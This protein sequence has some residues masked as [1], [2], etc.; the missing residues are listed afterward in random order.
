MTPHNSNDTLA[1][2]RTL[3]ADGTLLQH[4][5]MAGSISLVC[6]NRKQRTHVGETKIHLH[7]SAFPPFERL[8]EIVE[9][10]HATGRPVAIHCVT[11]AE[12]VF[13]LA[14]LSEASVQAGDRIEHAS[15]TPPELMEQLRE[16][17]LTVVTQPNFIAERGDAYLADVPPR[18]QDW[19]YRCRGFLTTGIGLAGGTD[20]PFGDADPWN[21]MRAAVTRTTK[22]GELLGPSECLTPEQALALFL[23]SSAAPTTPRRITVGERADLCLLTAPWSQAREPPLQRS[24]RGNATRRRANL[25]RRQPTPTLTPPRPG[26][27]CSTRPCRRCVAGQCVGGCSHNRPHPESAPYPARAAEKTSRR[28]P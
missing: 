8:C 28:L 14:A 19:L 21:A 27:F 12:L 13:A 4:V 3:Q 11:E 22:S 26:S 10:S 1:L 7:E 25:R 20:A 6:D 17:D 2:F 24:G 5:R 15:V 16:L 18:E 9:T 23:G